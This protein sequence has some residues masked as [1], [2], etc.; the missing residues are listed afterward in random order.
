M[1]HDDASSQSSARNGEGISLIKAATHSHSDAIDSSNQKSDFEEFAG[2][3]SPS[4]A[5]DFDRTLAAM[6]TIDPQDWKP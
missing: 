2:S 3:W 5:A 1:I 4:A 6:R